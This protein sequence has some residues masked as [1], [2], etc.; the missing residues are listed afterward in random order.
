MSIIDYIK[1]GKIELIMLAVKFLILV[2]SVFTGYGLGYL[3]TETKLRLAK[4]KLFQFEAFECRQCLSFHIAWVTS[5]FFALLFKD[6][7]MLLIGVAFA[8]IL[9]IGLK[10]DQKKKTIDDINS[11][12]IEEEK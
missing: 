12:H 5:T 4:W 3:F 11:Y 7:N 2:L 10:I 8:F 9:W 6:F 1:K